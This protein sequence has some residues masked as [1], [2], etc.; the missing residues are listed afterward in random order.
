MLRFFTAGESHGKALVAFLEGLPSGLPIDLVQMQGEL[1]KRQRGYG[2]SNR[3]KLEKDEAQILGGIRGGTTTGAP[4]ALMIANRDAENW[5]HVMSVEPPDLSLKEAQEQF[6]QK[7]ITRFRPGHADL[8]GTIKYH[9]NDVRDVLERAS[10]RETASRV[11]V[12]ALCEQFLRRLGIKCASHVIQIGKVRSST[13]VDSLD[14]D[15]LS[16]RAEQSEVFCLDADASE[17]IINLIQEMWQ[18]GD[19]LG[20]IVE[21]K[22]SN[23]PIGLGSYTQWDKKIDGRLAQALMSIQAIKA[24]EIG[25]GTESAAKPGSKVHDALFPREPGDDL[26]FKRKTNH[27]GGLEG[28]MTNGDELIVR[29]F[30]KPIPTLRAGLDSLNF[31]S[32][33]AER[34]H[35]ERSDV[36]AVPAAAVVCKAMV[37]IVLAQAVLEKFGGDCLEEVEAALKYHRDYCSQ[38]GAKEARAKLI[39]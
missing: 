31:P 8:A 21:I 7:A 15:E 3:Q 1:A 20:G 17:K 4:I 11:A 18:E 10:A 16:A 30:M 28:G 37:N 32:F 22:A 12:G 23:V 25:D 35:Y 6:E 34:A 24:V 36:C 9:Q 13:N 33:K 29:A 38:L 26:P 27:A 39:G 2:R 14:L 19:T 5:R